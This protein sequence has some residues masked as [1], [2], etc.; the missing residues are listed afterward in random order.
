MIILSRPEKT[1]RSN[2][3]EKRLC[4]AVKAWIY[5]M[6]TYTNT[7]MLMHTEW[8]T[9]IHTSTV[10]H[11]NTYFFISFLDYSEGEELLLQVQDNPLIYVTIMLPLIYILQTSLNISSSE[12]QQ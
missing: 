9:H 8:Q 12:L 7:F 11:I 4:I 10:A 3:P 6:H 1:Q 2:L 5:N